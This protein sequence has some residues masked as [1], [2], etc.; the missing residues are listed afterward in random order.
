MR[1]WNWGVA[2][3]LLL[4]LRAQACAL[5]MDFYTYDGFSETVNAFKRVSLVFANNE[6]TTLFFVAVVFGLLF[7]GMFT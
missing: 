2:F 4:T 1:R 7:G 5:D 3:L 6:Y